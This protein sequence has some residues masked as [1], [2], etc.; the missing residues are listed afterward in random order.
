MKESDS[1]EFL[2]RLQEKE[3][4]RVVPFTVLEAKINRRPERQR[5]F[6][7]TPALVYDMKNHIPRK[8]RPRIGGGDAA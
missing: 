7:Q 2:R 5:L 8:D 1:G 6:R 4:K 3:D